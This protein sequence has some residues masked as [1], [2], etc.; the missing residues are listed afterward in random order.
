MIFSIVI[1][2]VALTILTFTWFGI[3]SQLSLAY[4]NGATLMQ[5]QAQT[6]AQTLMSTGVPANWP[7]LVNTSNTVT[8][9]DVS[10]G[11]ASAQGS[12]RLSASKLYT[13]MAMANTNYQATK[14]IL[15]TAFDYYINIESSSF[16][17]TIGSSPAS[18]KALTTYVEKK[19]VFINGQPAVIVIQVWTGETIGIV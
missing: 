9:S 4:G 13:F 14:P 17:I 6:L 12:T 2:T 3:N 15:G 18:G 19:G 7:S 1:F 5:L 10:I 16:N 8:W 11:L